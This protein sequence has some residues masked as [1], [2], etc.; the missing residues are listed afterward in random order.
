MKIASVVAL[1]IGAAVLI[2]TAASAAC[3]TCTIQSKKPT[4]G[5]KFEYKMSCIHD[6]S[7]DEIMNVVIAAKD[8]EAMK[9][10]KGKC[11]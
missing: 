10:A 7:G 5:G 2:P 8:D 4:K 3:S 1:V 9:L 6:T 11:P